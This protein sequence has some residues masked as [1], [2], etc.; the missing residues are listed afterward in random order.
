MQVNSIGNTPLILACKNKM[1]DVATLLI[2]TFGENC[3][4]LLTNSVGND[5]LGYA[6]MNQMTFVVEFINKYRKQQEI[7]NGS[8]NEK[9]C[10]IS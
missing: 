1:N 7:H 10:V 4:P 8:H 5:A 9:C 6:N 3:L 2:T